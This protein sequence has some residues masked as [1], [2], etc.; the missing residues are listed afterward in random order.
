MGRSGCS[1]TLAGHL[2]RNQDFEHSDRAGPY[3]SA[4]HPI[5]DVDLG[6]QLVRDAAFILCCVPLGPGRG[7]SGL[8]SLVPGHGRP[9]I[10]QGAEGYANQLP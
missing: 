8:D 10:G 1:T 4:L 3:I 5:H 9:F 2:C 7:S 6:D